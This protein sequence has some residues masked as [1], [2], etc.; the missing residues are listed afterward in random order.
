MLVDGQTLIP[1]FFVVVAAGSFWRAWSAP[2]SFALPFPLLLWPR[3]RVHPHR[4]RWLLVV[5][6][7]EVQTITTLTM[8]AGRPL[9]SSTT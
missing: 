1:D 8:A 2:A 7:R 4:S 6:D 9:R 5:A 3:Q